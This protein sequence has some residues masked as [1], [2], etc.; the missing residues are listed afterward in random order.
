MN[1][2]KQP[3]LLYSIGHSN[4]TIERF[5]DLLS[6][7]GIEAVADVRSSPY[8]RHN[9]QFSRESLEESLT[10]SGIRYVFMGQELGARRDEPECYVEGRVV[11]DRVAETQAFKKGIGRLAEG[12]SKMNI[13]MLCA[14]QDPLTC[15]RG[16]LIGRHVIGQVRDLVHILPDGELETHAEAE[17]RLL[18]ECKLDHN[19]LFR[20]REERLEDAYRERGKSIAY[21]EPLPNA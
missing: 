18:V 12:S 7:H 8:S 1:S 16:I 13:A 19:D 20:T 10:H 15:H 17:Q 21:E 6:E 4:H 2:P 9:P 11:Y 14:E 3:G 5:L